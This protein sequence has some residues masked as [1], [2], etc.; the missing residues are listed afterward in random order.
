MKRYDLNGRVIAFTGSTGGLGLAVAN[1][2]RAKGAKLALLDLNLDAV[3][4]QA[5]ALGGPDVA[6]GWSVN[7][8]SMD[9]LET[10]LAAAAKHFGKV[11]V[12]IAGAGIAHINAMEVTDL[13][14]CEAVVDINLTGVW[15]TFKAALPYVEATQGY[16]LA[17]SS[18]AAFVHSPLNTAYTATKAGVWAL[19]NSLRLEVKHLGIG[20]GTLHPTFFQTPI[21]QA[22]ADG[23]CSEYIWNGHE[24]M[25]KFAALDDVVEALV[26]CIEYRRQT[27]TVPKSNS[28]AATAPGLAR[29]LVERFGFDEA[30]VAEAMKIERESK[31]RQSMNG[32]A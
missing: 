24:G 17:V 13:A 29:K 23:P 9:S 32:I 2:L 20:V 27:V 1:A 18:M 26:G 31:T 28:L 19:S 14:Y 25:W 11:D 22:A 4:K 5:A 12:V 3:E 10:A 16:L 6:A 7:V 30:R 15:R 21:M 8:R